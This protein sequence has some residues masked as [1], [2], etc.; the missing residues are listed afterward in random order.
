M[1]ETEGEG[2]NRPLGEAQRLTIG[3]VASQLGLSTSALRKWEQR[4]AFP[5]PDRRESGARLYSLQ[6]LARLREIKRLLDSGVR[7]AA[8]FSATESCTAPLPPASPSALDPLLGLEELLCNDYPSNLCQQLQLQL[9]QQG[10]IPF[11]DHVAVPLM[12][13]VGERWAQGALPVFREHRI[14]DLLHNLLLTAPKAPPQAGTPLVLIAIPPGELHS[15][16]GA[17]VTAALGSIG[18]RCIHFY[19]ALPPCELVNAAHAYA[20]DIVGIS[21]SRYAPPRRTLAFLNE[22]CATLPSATRLWV[23]GEGA[24]SLPRLPP[25][26]ELL[27]SAGEACQAAL[28]PSPL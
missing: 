19:A 22:L 11:V 8:A 25:K 15:L 20:A 5:K 3:V 14:A 23:G 1:D 28:R 18:V 27:V 26:C 24:G 16:G 6:D 9:Q 12:R 21:I 17:M 2:S 10:V 7:T 4:F 13:A